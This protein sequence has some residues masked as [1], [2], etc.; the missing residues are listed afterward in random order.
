MRAIVPVVI[1]AFMTFIV[2]ISASLM[3]PFLP[4]YAQSLGSMYGID[5]GLFTSVFLLTRVFM[6]SASGMTSDRFGRRK[7]IILGIAICTASSLSFAFLQDWYVILALRAMQGI[8]SSMVWTPATA[9]VG[10]MTPLGKRGYAMGVYNSIS[11]SGWVLGPALGGGI[12]WYSRNALVMPLLDSFRTVFYTSAVLL[13]FSLALVLLFVKEPMVRSQ[14]KPPTGEGGT[15]LKHVSIDTSIRRALIAM[16]FLV[17]AFGL[18]VSLVEPLLVYH[19]QIVYGLTADEVTSSM[20]L[21]YSVSGFFIIAVQL[22]AGRL[23]DR[24]SKKM[25]IAVSALAAQFLTLLMPF[26]V[27]V[28]NIGELIVLWYA[29]YSLATPAY[30][31]LLQDLFPSRLRGTLTGVF[32]TIFDF[33]SLIGPIAGFLIYDNFSRTLP[34]IMSGVI[35]IAT[36]LALLA[37][38]KEP[39]KGEISQV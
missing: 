18:I 16:S 35:G 2:N 31:A 13:A 39:K 5:I 36:V 19:T 12:Q 28:A 24:F 7:L 25:M 14:P 22:L 20:A 29:F 23:A 32:L 1:L 6:N 10:D 3:T 26:A 17:F 27:N 9:L 8:G 21:I 37:F 30:L 15:A 11:M 4:V 38:A 33:G 34:F